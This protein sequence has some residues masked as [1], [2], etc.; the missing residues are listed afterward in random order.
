[1]LSLPCIWFQ[2]TSLLH[3]LY[4]I[5]STGYIIF[6]PRGKSTVSTGFLAYK[7]G[8]ALK[9][10]NDWKVCHQPKVTCK[11]MNGLNISSAFLFTIFPSI[12]SMQQIWPHAFRDQGGKNGS[13]GRGG[14]P[15]HKGCAIIFFPAVAE[16]TRGYRI[17]FG[18]AKE[19]VNWE[20]WSKNY[21]REVVA[22]SAGNE[23]MLL[24]PFFYT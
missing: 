6:S 5:Q 10:R 13:T 11:K 15:I 24:C 18:M 16:W 23:E 7:I 22:W 1:M 17:L 9:E 4:F 2:N 14:L 21:R 8:F 3:H 12:C 20:G 19:D